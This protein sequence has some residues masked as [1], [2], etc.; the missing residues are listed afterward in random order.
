MKMTE[1]RAYRT[2]V[3][4]FRNGLKNGEKKYLREAVLVDL[5][6]VCCGARA[7][8]YVDGDGQ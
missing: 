4:A 7:D 6:P 8:K 2:L 1:I 5:H 3:I